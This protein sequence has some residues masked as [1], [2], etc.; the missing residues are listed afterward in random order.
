MKEEMNTH[1]FTV[2]E[3]SNILK[4]AIEH[5]PLF[6]NITLKGEIS[7]M[8]LRTNSP[9]LYFSL[10][11]DD[12]IIRAVMFAFKQTNLHFTPKD[13]DEVIVK[14]SLSVYLK[15]GTYQIIV[16]EME[17][18]GRG[19]K[20]FALEELKK[21]LAA[22]GLFDEDKKRPIVAYPKNIGII[23]APKSAALKDLL[24]NINRRYPIVSIYIFPSLVQGEAAP[25]ALI[26]ALK[27]A[28]S[29]TPKLDTLIIA[30]GG[31]SDEDLDAFND[32]NLIRTVAISPIPIISAVGHEI[33]TTLV[34]LASDLRVSTPTAAAEKATPNKDDILLNLDNCRNALTSD[35][36][37]YLS[38]LKLKVLEYETNNF[39]KSPSSKYHDS[40]LKVRTYEKE[41]INSFK[42][43]LKRFDDMVKNFK[44][45]LEISHPKQ[46]LKRGYAL[47]S[48]EEKVITSVKNVRKN[49]RIRI[50]IA[51]GRIL[52]DVVEVEEKDI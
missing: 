18:A 14:G 40:L 28:Y 19:D 5:T 26:N 38:K 51:D 42:Y 30:R 17:E 47:V 15:Q 52:T 2:S 22:E 37:H 1:V 8:S 27:L 25:N 29:F 36:R 6:R 3:I 34:D 20:L 24:F 39:F 10:K 50:Q 31:G 21:K 9:H 12:A 4:S 46:I 48:K 35:I 49:D 43:R 16:D 11:D 45:R 13:G 41:M 32:E 7:N 44:V 33:D 23:S